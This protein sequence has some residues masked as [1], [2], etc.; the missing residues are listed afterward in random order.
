[1]FSR[2]FLSACLLAA[3]LISPAAV[4][5]T[6]LLA[7]ADTHMPM[8]A[9]SQAESLDISQVLVRK[10]ERRLYLM[11][12][13]RVVKSYRVSLGDNPEGH[14]LYEGDERTPEGDYVLDWRNASSDFYKSIHISYPN[15]QDREQARAWGQ[16]PGGSIMIHGLPN[17]V[18]DMAFAYRGLDWT[19][20]CIAVTNE[21]MDEIWQLVAD[22][23]PIR[24]V[25]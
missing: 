12:G 13:E 7:K 9:S 24:I 5:A 18:G 25:P 1:M 20:G 19:D 11:D 14:K 3:T 6:E 17:E 15:E 22:G 4:S 16:D 21:E 2:F 23:T 10:G 8:P